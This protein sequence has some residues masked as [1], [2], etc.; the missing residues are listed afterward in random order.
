MTSSKLLKAILDSKKKWFAPLPKK[1]IA[2]HLIPCGLCFDDLY[3]LVE[4]LDIKEALP[5]IPREIIDARNKR[6]LRAMD[7]SMK[8]EYLLVDLQT[9]Q[10][11]FR[12]C[13]RYMLAQVKREKAEREVHGSLP[14]QHDWL[15][16][17][18]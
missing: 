8:H 9:Q 13:L 7:H 5:S 2:N 1:T 3:D 16:K 18:L 12:S 15:V 14:L 17:P 10:T 11:L 6:L 4:S